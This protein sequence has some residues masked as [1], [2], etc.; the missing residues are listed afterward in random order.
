MIISSAI[1]RLA[2]ELYHCLLDS[3]IVV[4]WHFAVKDVL[5][6]GSESDTMT[7]SSIMVQMQ[8]WR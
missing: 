8:P 5:Q 3:I 1:T 4:P 2:I 6:T 7:R